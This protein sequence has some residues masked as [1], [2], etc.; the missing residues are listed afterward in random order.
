V[1]PSLVIT[2]AVTIEN[3]PHMTEVGRV[4]AALEVAKALLVAEAEDEECVLEVKGSELVK[5][6]GQDLDFVFVL[7]EDR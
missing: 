6:R 4:E 1:R 2:I 5:V 3:S 7:L